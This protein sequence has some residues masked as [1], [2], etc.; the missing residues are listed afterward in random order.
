[1]NKKILALAICFG[2][3]FGNVSGVYSAEVITDEV[4]SDDQMND[5]PDYRSNDLSDVVDE[6]ADVISDNLVE[7]SSD[8]PENFVDVPVE[9]TENPL[10]ISIESPNNSDDTEINTRDDNIE[11][12]AVS[13]ENNTNETDIEEI[14]NSDGIEKT[15]SE[16]SADVEEEVEEA[17]LEEDL[18]TAAAPTVQYHTHVQTYGWENE[19]KSNGAMSGTQGQSKRLEGIEIK[20]SGEKNLGI[21]YKTHIQT[22]GWENNWK[23]DGAMSGTSGQ[24]KRLEA[25]RIELTG[26][27]A[28]KY[29]VWYCVHAQHYGWLNWTKNGADAGTAGYAYRL[30][31]IKIRI[32]LKGSKAPAKEGTTNAAFYSKADGPSVNPT[33]T[34]VAYNTHVQTYG[35]QDYVYNGD[36]AGTSGKSK[37]LEGIH[38]YL[39]GQPYA[40]DI[41]Y[42]T[43]VQT[44]G[45]QG[46]K[47]N[48]EMSGTSGEA[49]R[50]EGIQIYL[51]GEMATHYDLYYRVH[52]Q[53]YGWL[54]WARNGQM[55]GTSGLA[56]RLEGINIL[57]VPKG[58]TAPGPTGKPNVAANP[59]DIPDVPQVPTPSST[60]TPKPTATPTPT[61][62]PQE[63]GQHIHS[64]GVTARVPALNVSNDFRVVNKKS[65]CSVCGAEI[66]ADQGVMETDYDYWNLYHIKLTYVDDKKNK[67]IITDVSSVDGY[68]AYG[69]RVYYKGA[70]NQP[71]PTAFSMYDLA[72]KTYKKI[73][74]NVSDFKI[75]DNS[76]YYTCFE[77]TT[78]DYG[79]TYGD[80]KVIKCSL[81]GN[82][83]QELC[84]VGNDN[85]V[86]LETW[87]LSM[88][89]CRH[90]NSYM[91]MKDPGQTTYYRVDYANSSI[92]QSNVSAWN[93][94]GSENP[95][96]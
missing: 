36:M 75:I 42:R 66:I 50:L 65:V 17:E 23:K 74:D 51:T 18:E 43:H 15:D 96:W 31:G 83:S 61:P 71:I 6:F 14:A 60:T 53:T 3:L 67:T 45:W 62:V 33:K 84:R 29:D 80:M 79:T 35:W 27:D 13:S 72:S 89:A 34:G 20:V 94:M 63:I 77:G 9:I 58:S 92:S 52:A 87:Q 70:S 25:I 46:W 26:S 93:S 55:A 2:M 40:G 78:T 76:I 95:F 39:T 85:A 4:V 32:Q 1:M 47:K 59:N 69:N 24:A 16:E 57:L 91:I 64:W 37:R 54:D 11:S 28:S 82:N 44:Y 88:Y 41:V 73:S 48:G 38:I 7:F 49:K 5:S 8:I 81:D 19:W 56:K 90:G 12:N 22:Y 68:I 10:D 30:E 86:G 21:R